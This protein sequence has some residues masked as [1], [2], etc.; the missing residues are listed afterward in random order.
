MSRENIAVISTY[1]PSKGGVATYTKYLNEEGFKE[2][3]NIL[4]FTNKVQTINEDPKN[5][6]RIWD[7]NPF[8]IFQILKAFKKY[9]IKKAHFQ[10][11]IFLYGGLIN[12]ILFLPLILLTRLYGIKVFVTVHGVPDLG[13]INLDFAKENFI[14]FPPFFIKFGFLFILSLINVISNN[15]IVHEDLFKKRMKEQYFGNLN[16]ITVIH[17]GVR[18]I[19]TISKDKACK[20]LKLESKCKHILYF[21]YIT[22]YKGVDK[23]VN[24]FN[25]ISPN[26]PNWKLLIAGGAHPRAKYDKKYKAWFDDLIKKIKDSKQITYLDFIPENKIST[27]FSASDV[28]IFPYQTVLSSSG[29]MALAIGAEK[30]ILLSDKFKEIGLDEFCYTTRDLEKRI[31][32]VF[33]KDVIEFKRKRTWK[34]I[35]RNT[36]YIW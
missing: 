21:G 20:N 22:G 6:L 19:Q 28:V 4:F 34:N 14:S 12:A 24:D 7:K 13:D 16:K 33:N 15:I 29:P 31:K 3:P 27:I 18:N 25:S 2:D 36:K 10:H 23:L 5:V 30:P 9:K 11:E 35:S 26:N 8:F 17:H 1:W 32:Q